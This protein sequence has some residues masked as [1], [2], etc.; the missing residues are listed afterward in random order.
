LGLLFRNTTN[1]KPVVNLQ[2]HE[3]KQNSYSTL[4]DHTDLNPVHTQI[5]VGKEKFGKKLMVEK[6]QR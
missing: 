3:N 5:T 1:N 2:T 4:N 6:G